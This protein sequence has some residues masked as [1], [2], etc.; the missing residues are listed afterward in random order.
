MNT[1]E[2]Q[3]GLTV[4]VI[5][6]DRSTLFGNLLVHLKIAMNHFQAA[7]LESGQCTLL[8]VNNSGLQ[9]RPIVQQI[10]DDSSINDVCEVVIVDSPENNIS[11]GRNLILE[12]TQT[13]WLV[14]VDDDEFPKPEWISALYAQQ[15]VS[16]SAVV[17]GP[18]EPVYPQG[19]SAWVALLDLHNKGS[20]KTG[21]KVRHVATGNCLLDLQQIGSQRFDP[22]FGLSGGSDS[23]F[24]DQLAERG[25]HVVWREDA[26]VHETI[27][28]SRTSSRYMIFRCMTQGQNFKR[29]V[30]R[31]AELSQR[32]VFNLKALVQAPVGLVLGVL[33]LPVSGGMAAYWLKKG[34][35]NL[36]KLIRPSKR[37][38]G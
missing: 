9:S 20:L 22:E 37:L 28:A 29:V 26:I 17:A 34:F 31:E 25:L 23:L 19:T 15:Q 33:A 7:D 18:I 3:P 35:T 6:H 30:L 12:N 2:K 24:F 16:G 10:V 11:I 8:V 21:D 4:G 1:P 36:G 38:Y 27:P 13:R 14:F 5:T 32:L